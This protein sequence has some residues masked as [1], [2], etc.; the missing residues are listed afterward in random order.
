MEFVKKI[1]AKVNFRDKFKAFFLH[2]GLTL[3][4][5]LA[6][7]ALVRFVWYPDFYFRILDI[8]SIL[9]LL[10]L[11]D[12]VLGP[13]LTFVVYKKDK[14]SLKFDISVI[15]LL[16]LV[17]LAYGVMVVYKERPV[18]LVYTIDR[19]ETVV[20]NTEGVDLEAVKYPELRTGL[21]KV[22]GVDMPEVQKERD[23][24]MFLALQGGP[25]LQHT[26]YLYRP[27]SEVRANLNKSGVA[28]DRLPAELSQKIKTRWP[29]VPY[30]AL[31]VYPLTSPK[32][33]DQLAV[34][35]LEQEEMLGLIDQDP[36][37]VIYSS[38]Q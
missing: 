5:Y 15:V 29:D 11:V 14:P 1:F 18:Y 10:F 31:K 19:F 27:I 25:D 21:P 7:L 2:V 38:D 28:F 20:A 30:Q 32:G 34:W 8:V 37:P 13:L 24:L 23:D 16:Q 3:P 6:L 17:A 26:S 35:N 9:V 36:W 22:I 12:V 4:I 33:K